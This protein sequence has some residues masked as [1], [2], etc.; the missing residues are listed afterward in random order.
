MG[1]YGW[2]YLMVARAH[3]AETWSTSDGAAFA[4]ELEM[5]RELGVTGWELV[6]IRESSAGVIYY[7]KRSRA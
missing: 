7:F 5:F 3:G 6:A 4:S 1:R 2:S